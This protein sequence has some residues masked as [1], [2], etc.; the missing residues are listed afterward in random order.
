MNIKLSIHW[1]NLFVSTALHVHVHV[2][3]PCLKIIH[4][5]PD[6]LSDGGCKACDPRHCMLMPV[7]ILLP[8][9]SPNPFI[10]TLEVPVTN[11]NNL[12]LISMSKF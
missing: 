12:A 2:C 7:H 5:K 9:S 10:G 11:C 4:E 6:L 1:S 3:D 8:C